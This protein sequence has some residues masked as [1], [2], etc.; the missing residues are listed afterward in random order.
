LREELLMSDVDQAVRA[1]TEA[2]A[3]FEAL[4]R[5]GR[6][7][8]L[9]RL[10]DALEADRAA[11]VS[12]A[13]RE[14][15]LGENRLGGELTRTCFQLRLFGEV[16][17]EGSYVEATI[18][19]AADTPIG[20]RPDLRRMLIPVGP[21]AVFG[22]SNFPLAFSVPGGDTA[23][24]L[25]AGCPVVAKAHPSHPATSRRAYEVM[26][27]VLPDGVLG[28][29]E[30]Y[31]AGAALVQHPEIKA[32]GFTGST[33]GGR[34]LFD[35][36][37]ARA[38][39]IPFYGELGSLNPL[40]VTPGAAEARPAEIAQ[41]YV[42]SA[43]LGTGQFCT[44]PGL[45]FIPAGAD[46]LRDELASSVA[47]VP[48]G[49]MLNDSIRDAYRDEIARRRADERLS[50]VGEG[51]PG[52]HP[53]V[54]A[55]FGVAAADLDGELLDECFGP[56]ALVIEYADAADLRA[57]LERLG[58][59]LTATVHAADGE[60]AAVADLHD[61]LR[62]RAGRLVFGGYPTGVAV[63]WAM[64]HGGPYPAA[65]SGGHTSVGATS[66]RRWLRPVTYQNAP[67]SVLPEE[68]RDGNP[69]GIP[70]R[71]DGRLELPSQ[72]R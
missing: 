5:D 52:E 12:V 45:M 70:R 14:S 71:V 53:G 34:A 26:A 13:D 23:S 69:A 30:G 3:R 31:E 59:Q 15:R 11:I 36:A 7:E 66:I 4:G 64:Q 28:L 8:V 16:L 57:A 44:K 51:V 9:D 33:A 61:V 67:Q 46:G 35:L 50:V 6:G 40:V 2:S 65:T 19:Q 10:A 48:A 21:V 29:V 39:P 22:A 25:A 63:T 62:N 18:D 41:G 38:E 32:V 1:A 68:L 37:A 54:P 27:A 58:G 42:A 49:P 47:A 43:T 56:S 20:P 72:L 55:L 24:A 17:R 60:D